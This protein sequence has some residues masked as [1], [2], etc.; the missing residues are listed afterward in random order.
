MDF[1]HM[2]SLRTIKTNLQ[3]DKHFCHLLSI[4]PNLLTLGVDGSRQNKIMDW[5]KL[6]LPESFILDVT[7]KAVAAERFDPAFCD[8]IGPRLQAIR[9]RLQTLGLCDLYP[10]TP[11]TDMRYKT[12]Y[13]KLWAT[14][15]RVRVD[16][17][18]FHVIGTSRV[19]TVLPAT[20]RSIEYLGVIDLDGCPVYLFILS[21][22]CATE[23]GLIRV[24]R[25]L[26]KGSLSPNY[27]SYTAARENYTL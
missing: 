8:T 27:K 25:N 15:K 14:A 7:C 19:H 13:R 5:R 18:A 20:V 4:S 22:E 6:L 16:S 11:W 3:I 17:N 2:T 23:I 12:S 21:N 10:D 9:F 26:L 1:T 24:P